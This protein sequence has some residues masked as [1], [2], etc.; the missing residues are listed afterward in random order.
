VQ[1]LGR[2]VGHI[3]SEEQHREGRARALQPLAQIA[4]ALVHDRA[5]LAQPVGEGLPP[6]AGRAQFR[7]QAGGTNDR[8]R[9]FGQAAVERGGAC[10][11]ERRDQPGLGPAGLGI[12]GKEDDARMA[13]REALRAS[14]GPAHRALATLGGGLLAFAAAVLFAAERRRPLRAQTQAE[15]RR[16]VRNLALGAMSMA[17]IR[18]IE[19]PLVT[20]LAE[21][22][23]AR[24]R[25]LVQYLPGRE[26]LGDAAAFLLMDYTIY[27]WHVATHR[28]PFLW[29]FH[30]VHHVDLDLDSTTALRFHAADM[31]IS[32]PYR[33]AQVALIGVSPRA[34]MVWQNWFFLSVLFHHSNLRLPLRWERMLARVLTTPRMHGIHHSTVRQETDSNWSSG[35]ALWDHL[36]GTFRLDVPQRAI[37]IGVPAYRDPRETRLGPALRLPF[38]RQRDA[39]APQPTEPPVPLARS[40]AET[41][42]EDAPPP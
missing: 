8:Q 16:V 26:W 23:R 6:G 12:A 33:A 7:S 30:L 5:I 25:G 21:R 18:L 13:H 1:V 19:T 15:P 35:L 22:A 36:H 29:R 4:F 2:E 38:V 40:P 37:A 14:G 34:L 3:R 32:A 9:A 10:G 42:E 39:W 11:P 28:V 31:A 24:R 17:V 27:L 20:P 41:R